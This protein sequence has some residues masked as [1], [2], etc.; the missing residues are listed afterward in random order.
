MPDPTRQ[1]VPAVLVTFLQQIPYFADLPLEH[2]AL[3]AQQAIYRTFEP[4]ESIFIEGSDSAGLWILESGTVKA[5]KLA[6]DGHEYVLRVFGVGDTF[7]DIAALD[8]GPNAANTTAIDNVTAWVIPTGALRQVLHTDPTV[9]LAVIQRLAGRVRQLVLQIED[10][11]LRSVTGRL[12]RFLLEQV[13]NQ[14]LA[15]PAVTRTLI[16]SYLATTPETVSRSLSSLEAM[17]AIRFDRHRIVIVKP[18]LLREL[19]L[20]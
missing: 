14:A 8:N 2:I 3:L 13:E 10:L 16:A 7:N 4:G 15:A 1:D 20:L 19:A 12:A 18:E 9:A 6:A 17:G 5:Y 11:A